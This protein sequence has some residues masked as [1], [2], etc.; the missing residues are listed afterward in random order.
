MYKRQ[1]EIADG[2]LVSLLEDHVVEADQFSVLWPAGR[3]LT[4]KVRTFVDFMAENLFRDT[5]L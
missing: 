5:G 1:D 2:R 3:Q 4:P